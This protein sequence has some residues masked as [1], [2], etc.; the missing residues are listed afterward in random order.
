MDEIKKNTTPRGLRIFLLVGGAI[1]IV[2]GLFKIFGGSGTT[3]AFVK[4]FN[5]LQVPSVEIRDDLA[6]AGGLLSGIGAKEAK[7]DYAGII[8]DLQITLAKLNDAAVK[9][10]STSV[11][12][13]EFQNMVDN[14]SDPNVKTTGLRFIDAFKTRNAAAL[15]MVND[16]KDLV[17]Q[18]TTYYN[19]VVQNLKVT[20]DVDKFSAAAN[21]FTVN[22]QGMTSIGAQYDAAANDF[23]KAA[24]FTLVK[25]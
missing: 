13:T 20:I 8:S 3:N 16:A 1:L 25:K 5:E 18:A 2:V 12:L 23:A 17:N 6:S 4:K 7:K 11:A 24:G 21:A 22:A 19:E 9:A 14:S 15:K 10:A